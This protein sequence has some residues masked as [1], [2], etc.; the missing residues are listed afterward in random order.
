MITFHPEGDVT[1]ADIKPHGG[2]RGGSESRQN[3]TS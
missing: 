2:V 3:K 1:S